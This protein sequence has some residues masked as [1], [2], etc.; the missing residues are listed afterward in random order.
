MRSTLISAVAAVIIFCLPVSATIIDIPDDYPTIQQGIDASSDGDTVLVQPGTYVEN[1]NF[2][3][4]NI[5]LGSL[6][7]TAGETI[8]DGDSSGSV[9][10]FENG[11][12][13]AAVICGFTIRNG[14]PDYGRGGGISCLLS[15]PFISHNIIANNFSISGG[16][17]IFCD[18]SSPCIAHVIISGN[19]SDSWGGGIGLD[20]WSSP[21]LDDVAIRA[22]TSNGVGGGISC[23]HDT[24]PNLTGCQIVENQART[25]GGGVFSTFSSSP[26]F[27]KCEI[28]YNQ[29]GHMGGGIFSYNESTPLIDRCTISRNSAISFGGGLHIIEGVALITNTIFWEN[30]SNTYSEIYGEPLIS[31]SN[32]QDTIWPGDGNISS[33]PLFIDLDNGDFHLQQWS[34]CIDAGDPDSPYDPDST[35]ADMGC[36]YY[37]QSVGINGYEENIPV[38]F[39]LSQNYP[40]PFNASTI[41]S[42]DLPYR[43]QVTI[44][45][46]DIL[47]RQVKTISDGRQSAGSHS[48]IWHVGDFSSGVYFYRLQAGEY[49]ETRKMML[50]K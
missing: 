45:V 11:E 41:I 19:Y 15:N 7:L 28:A 36:F 49:T 30:E 20:Y 13:D 16:G 8:I 2:N 40:N 9:V 12:T 18:N 23:R 46:F 47:G 26:E 4:H 17:G 48:L 21:N 44:D 37:D 10:V 35:I 43:L 22:N 5:V 25:Y 14:A 6:F 42:Y 27:R 3:G 39:S 33:N 29:G 24:S 32:I 31:Y 34:P 1:I 38:Q 50:A